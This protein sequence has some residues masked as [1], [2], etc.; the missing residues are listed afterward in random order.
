MS[1]LF[2]ESQNEVVTQIRTAFDSGIKLDPN[3]KAKELISSIKWIGT[4]VKTEFVKELLALQNH[5]S[6]AVRREVLS[7]LAT[8]GDKNLVESLESWSNFE[9][10][11]T[12]LI[13]LKTTIDK[14][15]RQTK[16][17]I[18]DKNTLQV[19]E[20]L[21]T[22]RQ[23]IGTQ[24][25]TVEGEIAEINVYHQ[26]VYF[27]LKDKNSGERLDC[28][29]F[30]TV[31]DRLDFTLNEGLS[32]KV[33]GKGG[34]AKNSSKLRLNVSFVELT[35]EGEFLRNLKLLQAKLEKEGLFDPLR[36]RPLSI[37]PKK[38]ALLVSRDSAA[39]SDFNKVLNERRGGIEICV[40]PIKT[41]GDGALK[42]LLNALIQVKE[43][44]SNP[45]SPLFGTET[46]VITRGGGS[47]DDLI[48]FNQEQIVRAIY[49]LPVP[50]V[51]AIGHEKDWSLAEMAADCR[52]STPTQAAIMVSQSHAEVCSTLN[53]NVLK[54]NLWMNQKYD[55]YR[56]FT[57]K[58]YLLIGRTI[59]SKIQEI[60]LSLNSFSNISKNLIQSWHNKIE[61]IHYKILYSFRSQVNRSSLSL[62]WLE[63]Y[64]FKLKNQITTTEQKFHSLTQDIDLYNP[65][66]ALARGYALLIDIETNT[67]V[68]K[69]SGYA[70]TQAKLVLQDGEKEV[71][72][73]L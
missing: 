58:Q 21:A 38:I 50:S 65:K 49:A 28:M 44:I 33:T 7:V 73:K 24:S 61:Q 19:S 48:L 6:V 4:H 52:A 68:E 41:Q 62:E 26:V 46:I 59:I 3:A 23:L 16:D 11:R 25:F 9:Q 37:L 14:L 29:A 18:K 54:I 64:R 60:E 71:E 55:S 12:T 70:K 5:K 36:K 63:N 43:D 66:K 22:I 27:A 39:E 32:I 8:I 17:L 47:K 13:L 42:I 35:G 53:Q 45:F 2:G 15:S 10:D 40:L 20:F 67:V 69:W 51:V 57:Q 30:Y 1:D 34:L 56:L 72:I 31:I